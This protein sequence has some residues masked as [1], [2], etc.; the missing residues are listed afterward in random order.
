MKITYC[1]KNSKQSLELRKSSS[2]KGTA[3]SMTKSGYLKSNLKSKKNNLSL[4]R[5]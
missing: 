4:R 5:V 1:F 2:G 3:K